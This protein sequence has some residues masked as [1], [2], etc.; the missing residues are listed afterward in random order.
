MAAKS[1]PSTRRRLRLALLNDNQRVLRMLCDW[2]KQHGHHC[3][4]AVVADFPRAHEDV[5]Q[6]IHKHGPDVVVYDVAMPY[7]SSWDLL[8]AI[9]SDPSLT[10]Q[11]FVVTTP[12][13]KKLEEAVGETSALE[14]AGLT[15]DLRRILKAVEAAGRSVSTP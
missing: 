13:K 11:P 1:S 4:T 3:V 10:A 7:A 2:F 15:T 8:D 6:F 5:P 12:N 14:L 9:R